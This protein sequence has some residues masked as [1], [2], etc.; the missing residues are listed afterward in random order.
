[1][2]HI[3]QPGWGSLLIGRREL[4]I[5]D[6]HDCGRQPDVDF[7]YQPNRVQFASIPI[8]N[9]ATPTA[10]DALYITDSNGDTYAVTVYLSGKVAVWRYTGGAWKS[11]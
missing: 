2:H 4:R 5:R 3:H 9:T 10:N 8:D 6:D 1:M 7:Q 11:L